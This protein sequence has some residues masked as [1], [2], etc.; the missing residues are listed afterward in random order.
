MYLE[1]WKSTR[2]KNLGNLKFMKLLNK[3]SKPTFL[4]RTPLTSLLQA[5]AIVTISVE[6][7]T[8]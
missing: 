3:P 6:L 5:L 8:S 7:T 2:W 4:L 1:E